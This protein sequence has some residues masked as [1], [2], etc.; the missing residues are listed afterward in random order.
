MLKGAAKPASNAECIILAQFCQQYKTSN[1]TAV[2]FFENAFAAE[3]GLVNDLRLH[4]RYNAACAAALAGCGRGKDADKLDA[5]KYAE[6][7]DKARSWLWDDLNAWRAV[8]E[9]RRTPPGL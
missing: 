5:K 9:R 7:R 1:L 6:L 3:P 2:H 8:L 4:L